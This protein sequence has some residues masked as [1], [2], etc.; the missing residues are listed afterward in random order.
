MSETTGSKKPHRS[1]EHGPWSWCSKAAEDRALFHGGSTLLL[2]YRALCRIESDTPDGSKNCFYASTTGIA[3]RCGL[4]A[5]TVRRFLPLIAQAGLAVIISGRNS[6]E[7]RS[8]EANR[9]TLLNVGQEAPLR[10]SCPKPLRTE[11]GPRLGRQERKAKPLNKEAARSGGACADAH[12][13]DGGGDDDWKP[14]Q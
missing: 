2:I 3:S 1:T 8:H 7:N 11:K 10:V 9:F 4:N 5:R 12:A 6:G 13:P 14:L